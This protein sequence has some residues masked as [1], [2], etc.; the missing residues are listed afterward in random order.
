MDL[1]LLLAVEAAA[2]EGLRQ[3]L[4]R[5]ALG[6]DAEALRALQASLSLR[7]DALANRLLEMLVAEARGRQ[8]AAGPNGIPVPDDWYLT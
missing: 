4:R 6:E 1:D 3:A 7:Q 5:L 8:E 2:E